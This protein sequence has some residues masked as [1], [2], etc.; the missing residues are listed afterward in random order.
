MIG[1]NRETVTK[2]LNEFVDSGI[3]KLYRGSILILNADAL[4]A[5]EDE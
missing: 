1:A 2:L 3:L 5:L 4:T